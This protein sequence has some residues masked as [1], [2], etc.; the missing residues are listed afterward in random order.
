M[1]GIR[2]SSRKSQSD[3]AKEERE[4]LEMKLKI[5][6]DKALGLKIIQTE[7]GRGI[8]VRLSFNI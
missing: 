3:I 2:K 1:S 5:K 6:D 7:M 8:E 4:K